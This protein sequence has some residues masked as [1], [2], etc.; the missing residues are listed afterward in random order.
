L[1]LTKNDFKKGQ[2]VALKYAGNMARYNQGYKLGTVKSA[3]K[4]YINVSLGDSFGKGIQFIVEERFE[5][6][7][8]LQKSNTSGDYELFPSEQAY[9]EFEEKEKKLF[10]IR[11]VVAPMYN[12]SKLS[13]DQVRRIY[14]II[15]E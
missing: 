9:F 4:K 1:I 13:V 10:D 6:D 15:K 12:Q 7:Y 8:L 11:S 5:R 3:G 2:T 14:N